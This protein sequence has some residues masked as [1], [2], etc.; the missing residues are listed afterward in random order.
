MF[1]IRRFEPAG[2][3]NV[4]C[5]ADATLL[6]A[7][8]D[9][10]ISHCKLGEMDIIPVCTVEQNYDFEKDKHIPLLMYGAKAYLRKYVDKRFN[11][12]FLGGEYIANDL[13]D[14]KD[15]EFFRELDR[16]KFSPNSSEKYEEI[17]DKAFKLAKKIEGG[18]KNVRV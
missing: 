11:S 16:L 4:I 1:A 13:I 12:N 10:L 6:N 14:E 8:D 3:D 18:M 9:S 2:V 5:Y 7:L 15:I 17:K